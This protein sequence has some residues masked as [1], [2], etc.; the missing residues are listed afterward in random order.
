MDDVP[1]E[2]ST[3]WRAAISKRA[4]PFRVA[5]MREQ[6]RRPLVHVKA[7]LPE[8][9]DEDLP[10]PSPAFSALLTEMMSSSEEE[11]ITGIANEV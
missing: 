6:L 1:D 7:Y 10:I 4:Y 3:R 2:R 8:S 5:S 11:N 9:D